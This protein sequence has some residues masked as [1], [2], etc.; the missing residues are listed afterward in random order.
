MT[1]TFVSRN[2]VGVVINITSN[3]VPVYGR[4]LV[5]RDFSYKTLDL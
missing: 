3:L 4:N 5:Q 2:D 1:E